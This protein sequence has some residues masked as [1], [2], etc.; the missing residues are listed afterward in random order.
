MATTGSSLA[1]GMCCIFPREDLGIFS[2][3]VDFV[4]RADCEDC[5]ETKLQLLAS[6]SLKRN[7]K[8][9]WADGYDGVL[10]PWV[11]DLMITKSV[12]FS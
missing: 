10:L 2:Q 9:E 12:F 5:R 8:V 4:K 6:H 7:F 1:R 3:C 11:H